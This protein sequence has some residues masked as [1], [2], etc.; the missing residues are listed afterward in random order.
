VGSTSH[1]HNAI[2][3]TI[4]ALASIIICTTAGTEAEWLRSLLINLPLYAIPVPHVC[5]HCDCHATIT[6]VKRK[7]Y[8]GKIQHIRLRHNIVRHLIESDIIF[9]NFL[10]S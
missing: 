10:R 2:L 7:I 9:M 5:I 8:N 4:R 6:R 1:L 3:Q